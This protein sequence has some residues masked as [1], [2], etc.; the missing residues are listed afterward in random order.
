MNASAPL[1]ILHVMRAPVGGLFRHVVDLAREQ[2]AR[3]HRVG[4][5]ADSNTGSP[6]AAETLNALN[7]SIALGVTRVPMSRQIGL[8]D[9]S[10]LAHVAQRALETKTDVLHGHGAKGGAYARL[11]GGPAI[12]AYTPHGGSLFYSPY[13]PMGLLY[14]AA[15]RWLRSRT[16]LALFESAFAGEAFRQFIGEPPFSRVV[17]NGISKTELEPISPAA[18]AA[19]FVF[20]GELRWRKG[21]DTVLEALAALS[22]EGWQGRAIFYGNGPDREACLAMAEKFG[23]TTKVDFPGESKP[24]LAFKSGQLLVIPSRQE[25]LPYIVLEAAGA[26]MPMITSNVGG[27]PEIFGPD[28]SALVPPGDAKALIA[29]IKRMRANRPLDLIERLHRRVAEHFSI[30]TMTEAV[31][32]AYAEARKRRYPINTESTN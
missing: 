9:R 32:A 30:E 3:G 6:A 31:L 24:R 16:D 19:D 10:A 22:T 20:I 23:L 14:F 1:R 27:I 15:E 7:K 8:L 21:I 17:H 11:A 26:R 13:S 5:V 25:S 28:A 29:A 18:D 4:I 2:T 12:R